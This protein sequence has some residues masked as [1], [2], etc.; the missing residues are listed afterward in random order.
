[1]KVLILAAGYGTR[2]YPLV[3]DTPKPLLLV[4]EKPL[5]DYILEKIQILKGLSQV[6]VVTNAKFF[7]V[8]QG[9]AQNH[10]KF[11]VDIKVLNDGT[12]TSEDRL[13]SIGDIHFVIQKEKIGHDLLVIGG[14]NLLDCSLD[15][16]MAFAKKVSP[17]VS[18]GLYDIEDRKKAKIYGVVCLDKDDRVV[19]FEEKPISPKSSLIAMCLYY[20]PKESLGL[21]SDYLRESQKADTAGDYINW[22]YQR[23][24]VYGFKFQG[25]WY[26]IGS[27]ES[28]QEAQKGFLSQT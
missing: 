23:E 21:V 5:I 10:K 2:L 3:K 17:R 18:I 19:S 26:D 27:I 14:D 1:M 24:H 11:P 7:K 4:N 13:G 15:D 9:W 28:Y 6:L 20:F 8:F 25:K 16:Y 12:K 22:L